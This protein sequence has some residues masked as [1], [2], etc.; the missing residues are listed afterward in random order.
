MLIAYYCGGL[1]L[2]LYLVARQYRQWMRDYPVTGKANTEVIASGFIPLYSLY[3]D[4][5]AAT[6]EVVA[7]ALTLLAAAI[8]FPWCSLVSIGFICCVIYTILFK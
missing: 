4:L 8:V 6:N 7:I 5:R 2:F 1:I 3:K